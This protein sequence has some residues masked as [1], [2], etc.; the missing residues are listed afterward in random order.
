M[1]L[2]KTALI[3]EYGYVRLLLFKKKNGVFAYYDEERVDYDGFNEKG[4]VNPD[5]VFYKIQNLYDKAK[6]YGR[7]DKRALVVLPGAFF[8]YAVA[9]QDAPVSSGT[10]TANDVKNLVESCGARLPSYEAVQKRPLAF[11]TFA[12]PVIVNPVGEKADRLRVV[13]SV[14]YLRLGIKEIFDNCAKRLDKYFTYT[15]FGAVASKK[16]DK[17]RRLSER[18]IIIFA[19]GNIDVV[20]SKDGVPVDVRSDMFGSRHVLYSLAEGMRCP[21]DEAE[22]VMLGANLN[23]N[24]S[25]GDVYRLGSKEYSVAD[26]NTFLAEA[27]IYLGGEVKKCIDSMETEKE[28]VICLTGSAIC[29]VRGIKEL[30]EDETGAEITVLKS[31]S[32]NLEGCGNYVASAV[33]EYMSE[34]ESDVSLKDKIFG[35]K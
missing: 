18:I 17:E 35:R 16:A 33:G 31:N 4:F 14:E 6:V 23:L 24:F 5:D 26:V 34:C 9:E 8:K 12:N 3:V 19:D 28:P 1:A 20:L 25:D 11:K 32:I 29:A 15:S 30:F 22:E 21:D 10:V 27:F 7:I 13:T 2:L